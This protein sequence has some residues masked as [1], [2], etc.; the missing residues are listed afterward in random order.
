VQVFFIRRGRLIGCESFALQ[1][2]EEATESQVMSSF[3]T[4][5]YENAA[6]V[7]RTLLLQHEIEE[8][9]V[10]EEWLRQKRR[11]KVA[12]RVPRR[13]EKRQLVELVAKNACETLE[14][15]G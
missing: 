4:Q 15:C 6:Q 10:I 13:G 9:S 3:V 7:P 2:T 12:I 8:W 5:F 1:G 11:D 14:Q